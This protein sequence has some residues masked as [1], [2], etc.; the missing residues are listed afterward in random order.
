[1]ITIVRVEMQHC[2]FFEYVY[3]RAG[4]DS[5]MKAMHIKMFTSLG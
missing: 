4:R 3:I 2:S 5:R 1:M